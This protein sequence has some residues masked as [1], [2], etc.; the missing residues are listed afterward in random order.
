MVS[1]KTSSLCKEFKG[2]N[3][4]ANYADTVELE[5]A[6]VDYCFAESIEPEKLVANAELLRNLHPHLQRHNSRWEE[7]DPERMNTYPTLLNSY[8][9]KIRS[10]IKYPRKM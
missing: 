10:I 4:P 6:V 7:V 8:V 2:L 9:T 5:A 3:K 1:A